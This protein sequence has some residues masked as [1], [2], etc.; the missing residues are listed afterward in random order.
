[1]AETRGDT[2]RWTHL[3]ALFEQALEQPAATRADWVERA[4]AGDG[5]LHAEVLSIRRP[6][7]P[8]DI[9]R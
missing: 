8:E 9:S 4:C 7:R 2:I 3:K 6:K 1:M 5:T